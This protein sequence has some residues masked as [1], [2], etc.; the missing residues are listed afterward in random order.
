MASAL[1]IGGI[2]TVSSLAT[3]GLAGPGTEINVA[4]ALSAGSAD[5]MG[6]LSRGRENYGKFR[7]GVEKEAA[8]Q[9]RE[10]DKA[11]AE[12]SDSL[13]EAIKNGD[14]SA[15]FANSRLSGPEYT[16][17]M[18]NLDG[19]I[20]GALDAASQLAVIRMIEGGIR[21]PSEAQDLELQEKYNEARGA[22][23]RFASRAK[24]VEQNSQRLESAIAYIAQKIEISPEDVETLKQALA[25]PVNARAAAAYEEQ[26]PILQALAQACLLR[27]ASEETKN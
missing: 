6:A 26:R 16:D 23:S 11:S 13:G 1:A 12:R 4:G 10:S 27:Q 14:K 3:Q 20:S 17:L 22:N 25:L 5:F 15:S 21:A 8:L 18:A 9:R 7:E 2:K 19:V 24:Q